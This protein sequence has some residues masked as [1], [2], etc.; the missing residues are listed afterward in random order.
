M[1]DPGWG[2][3]KALVYTSL[4]VTCAYAQ[5]ECLNFCL[6][7]LMYVFGHVFDMFHY[8]QFICFIYTQH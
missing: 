7:G 6:V 2:R 5:S 8:C 3:Q 4:F 1:K